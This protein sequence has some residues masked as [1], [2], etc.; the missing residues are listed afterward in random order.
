MILAVRETLPF[1]AGA[2]RRVLVVSFTR[3][4]KQDYTEVKILVAA[5]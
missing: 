5:L 1:S 2:Q 4:Y 3:L